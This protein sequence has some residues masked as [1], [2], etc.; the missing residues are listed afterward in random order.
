MKR[1]AIALLPILLGI[2]TSDFAMA[3]QD[4]GGKPTKSKTPTKTAPTPTPAPK[5]PAGSNK[6]SGRSAPPPASRTA[7]SAEV[8]IKTSPEGCSIS[9]DAKPRGTTNRDGILNIP[10]LPPASY[11]LTVSRPGYQ[12]HE[13][14]IQL[15]AGQNETVEVTLTPLPVN[16]AINPNVSGARIEVNGQIYNDFADVQLI[17]GTYQ[18]KVSRPGYRTVVREIELRTAKPETL[19][20]SMERVSIEELLAQAEQSFSAQRYDQAIAVCLD[21]LSAQP[22]HPRAVLLLGQSNFAKEKHDDSVFYL[23]KAVRLGQQAMLP[24]KH[25]HSTV[26]KGD[27]LCSGQL[28]ILKER[29]EFRAAASDHSFNIPWPKVYELSVKPYRSTSRLQTRVGILKGRKED[30]QNFNF[31]P[32]QADLRRSNPNLLTSTEVYCKDCWPTVDAIY[33]ILQQLRK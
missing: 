11:I 18:I 9:I 23:V 22:D 26:I 17:P 4:G 1:L 24:I 28:V 6:G 20:V 16:L 15:T 14:L 12:K 21:L 19:S 29:L 7:P 2:S 10:K 30:K 31:F 13:S 8:T 25:H 33:Q 27:D 32:A 3:F 5:P